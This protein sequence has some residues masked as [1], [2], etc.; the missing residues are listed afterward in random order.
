MA[1]C[2]EATFEHPP[3]LVKVFV[4]DSCTPSEGLKHTKE[5]IFI[6]EAA[7]REKFILVSI[8]IRRGRQRRSHHTCAVSTES[9][10]VRH[11]T[12]RHT[13]R[14]SDAGPGS[15][16]RPWVSDA[17][18]ADV[19]RFPAHCY[20]EPEKI[21]KTQTIRRLES[22]TKK[23]VTVE[24]QRTM[25]KHPCLALQ[26]I[27]YNSASRCL[28]PPLGEIRMDI[29]GQELSQD[30]YG[31]D[32]TRACLNEWK[33]WNHP[34]IRFKTKWS[35][36]NPEAACERA[37]R[38]RT[39]PQRC[40]ED[41]EIVG[42]RRQR[43]SLSP[44]R[45]DDDLKNAEL[46]RAAFYDV[47]WRKCEVIQDLHDQWSTDKASC[48]GI[49]SPHHPQGAFHSQ[50][51]YVEGLIELNKEDYAAL[52]I[53][54]RYIPSYELRG[55]GSANHQ[56]CS[57]VLEDTANDLKSLMQTQTPPGW[58]PG[59]Y[60]DLIL[61]EHT[62]QARKPSMRYEGIHKDF[63]NLVQHI[64]GRNP[65]VA[66]PGQGDDLRQ[67]WFLLVEHEPSRLQQDLARQRYRELSQDF[68]HL[69][70][71]VD[72]HESRSVYG[73]VHDDLVLLK[74][75]VSVRSPSEL[76]ADVYRDVHLLRHIMYRHTPPWLYPDIQTDLAELK[77]SRTLLRLPDIPSIADGAM[78]LNQLVT[79][80]VPKKSSA[81]V[82]GLVKVL[83]SLALTHGLHPVVFS[84]IRRL[85]KLIQE[86]E[87]LVHDELATC[88]AH[89]P[90]ILLERLAAVRS[91]PGWYPSALDDLECLVR[92]L[93]MNEQLEWQVSEYVDLAAVN[94]EEVLVDLDRVDEHP[95]LRPVFLL[96]L[97]ERA[98]LR[99]RH[100]QTRLTAV[101]ATQTPVTSATGDQSSR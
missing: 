21:R 44:E 55:T 37:F 91:P 31:R 98:D 46:K 41:D 99:D 49:F 11:T 51:R 40:Q 56:D 38:G 65:H 1:A 42:R 68:R 87:S 92:L 7:I 47:S 63:V 84:C 101:T 93:R 58:Y 100:R 75:W 16:T 12:T 15:D 82:K 89:H 57:T 39:D 85:H 62:V 36:L 97:Q 28:P 83:D 43:H 20:R 77:R 34:L 9:A 66:K 2:C 10:S 74:Y 60:R 71:L 18:R 94:Y 53:D 45:W 3:S 26:E 72:A 8:A 32:I 35:Y 50:R 52:P 81:K 59:L 78:F 69:I 95:S 4:A 64:C 30:E 76:Y 23:C 19:V 25:F 88:P 86:H 14:S 54:T 27:S 90:C 80:H 73:N 96:L 5:N 79:T 61:F 48:D 33:E 70:G 67:F 24:V 6:T 17:N 29:H 13:T 22:L